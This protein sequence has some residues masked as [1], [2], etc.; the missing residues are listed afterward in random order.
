[1][2]AALGEHE[3][4][5]AGYREASQRAGAVLDRSPDDGLSR[6]LALVTAYKHGLAILDGGDHGETVDVKTA[7]A[8]LTRAGALLQA[9]EAEGR[10]RSNAQVTPD[11][12]RAAINRV[13]I[14]EH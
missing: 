9:M 5:L 6:E 3:S 10:R 1:M 4:A 2:D 8:E 12:I 11:A 14:L 13:E 7:R